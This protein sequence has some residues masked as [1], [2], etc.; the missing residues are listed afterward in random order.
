MCSIQRKRDIKHHIT[1]RYF[2]VFISIPLIDAR[3]NTDND[4]FL[5]I[6]INI[7]PVRITR[8]LHP[9]YSVSLLINQNGIGNHQCKRRHPQSAYYLVSIITHL[10]VTFFSFLSLWND[11]YTTMTNIAIEITCCFTCLTETAST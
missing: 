9:K 3:E 10:E 2:V 4:I 1:V 7:W 8:F 5:R 11:W 6:A